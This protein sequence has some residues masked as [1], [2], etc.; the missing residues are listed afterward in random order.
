MGLLFI[1][2]IIILILIISSIIYQIRII[3][4]MKRISQIRED[5]SHAMIHDMKT[6][7][8]TIYMALNFLHSGRLDDK[9]EMKDKYFKI[10]ESEAD[11]LL[12]LTNKVLTVS[13]LEKHKL[14]MVKEEISLAPMIEQLI[15]K[16]STKVSKPDRKSVV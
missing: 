4:R 5:F 11:H 10:A 16:F 7:L 9:P 15:D 3:N 12:T 2:T 13:K 14:E 8:S 1:A 6:P